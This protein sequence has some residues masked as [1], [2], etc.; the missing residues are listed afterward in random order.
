MDPLCTPPAVTAFLAVIRDC[1]A[2]AATKTVL[3]HSMRAWS[4]HYHYLRTAL[5]GHC[6]PTLDR[7]V[8]GSLFARVTLN[9]TRAVL[10][11]VADTFRCFF[12]LPWTRIEVSHMHLTATFPSLCAAHR[13]AGDTDYIYACMWALHTRLYA[14]RQTRRSPYGVTAPSPETLREVVTDLDQ[15]ILVMLHFFER[16]IPHSILCTATRPRPT[17]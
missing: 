6:S 10:D 8:H 7:Q 12:H 3:C 4:P 15:Y 16:N 13:L 9:L 1:G 14:Y 5:G 17:G 11:S 2:D